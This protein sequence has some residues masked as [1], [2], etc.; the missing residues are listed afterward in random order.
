MRAYGRCLA[1]QAEGPVVRLHEVCRAERIE[2]CS[3]DRIRW[4]HDDDGL[5]LVNSRT[6]E[7]LRVG[8]GASPYACRPAVDECCSR[9]FR[10]SE[11]LW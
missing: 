8:R 6:A 7:A 9:A 4:T 10:S 3:G 5:G 11:D 1:G 2:L